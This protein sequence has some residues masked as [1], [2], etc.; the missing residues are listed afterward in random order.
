MS[1]ATVKQQL[2]IIH[3]EHE[4]FTPKEEKQARGAA[5]GN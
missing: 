2:L 4:G 5:G 1:E 3:R